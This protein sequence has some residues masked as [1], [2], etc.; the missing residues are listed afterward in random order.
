[1]SDADIT[2]SMTTGGL[3]SASHYHH[4]H[5]TDE[6]LVSRGTELVVVPLARGTTSYVHVAG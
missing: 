2:E 5:R 4:T 6:A 3:Y 1:M